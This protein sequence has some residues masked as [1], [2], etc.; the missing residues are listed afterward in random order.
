MRT[1]TDAL[2]RRCL[3]VLADPSRPDALKVELCRAQLR[4][5]I[6]RRAAAR[7]KRAMER[8]RQVRELKWDTIPNSTVTH[9][10]LTPPGRT[11]PEDGARPMPENSEPATPTGNV[12]HAGEV[13]VQTGGN[14]RPVTY[15]RSL[16][17]QFASEADVK[18]AFLAGRVSLTFFE[19]HEVG[20]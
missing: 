18:A 17:V 9:T 8:I 3:A 11:E 2:L 7:A 6:A 1:E 20:A 13:R 15:P 10:A 19:T 16:L 5:L 14:P 4:L 12:V